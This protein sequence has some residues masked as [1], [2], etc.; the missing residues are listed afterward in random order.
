[1]TSYPS[2]SIEILDPKTLEV[3]TFSDK[4]F[5]I[6]PNFIFTGSFDPTQDRVEFFVYSENNVL[7]YSDG[8]FN[9]W[10]NTL[11][12][13]LASQGISTL[14]LD[15]VQAVSDLGI[16]EGKIKTL[17]NFISDELGSSVDNPF[18]I[19]EISGDRTELRLQ[20]NFTSNADLEVLFTEFKSRI[21]S[22]VYFDEFY[23]NF[24]D[25]NLLI[26][27]NILLDTTGG[28]VSFFVKLYEPLP[29]NILL[30]DIVW[31]S[32]KVGESTSYLISFPETSLVVDNL[33]YLGGPNINID[34][35][36]S[37]GI[38]TAF[39]TYSTLISSSL[40]SSYNQLQNIL[41][42]KGIQITPD[43]TNF[44]S[45]VFFSNAS[46][47]LVNFYTKVS[48]IESYQ[49]DLSIINSITG[50]TSQ[51]YSVSASRVTIEQNIT[52]IISNFDGYENY[53]YFQSGS[54]TW[55][56]SNSTYPY[57]LYS[58][59]SSQVLTWLGSSDET[60][61]YY[62]GQLYSSSIY[63][64]L[65]QNNLFY[66]IPAYLRN[67]PN[68][69]QYFLFIEMMGQFFDNI[70]IYTDAITDK[71]KADNRINDGVSK[72]LVATV[73]ESL[74]QKLYTNQFNSNDIYSS[75]IGVDPQ[76]NLSPFPN[77]TGTYPVTGSGLEYIQNFVSASS[78]QS[79]IPLTEANQRLYKRIYHI[80]P[81][82]VKKKGTLEALKLIRNAYGIPSTIL[83]FNE[84]GGK[85]GYT[86][87]YDYFNDKYNLAFD[88]QASASII[89]P[90]ESLNTSF[91]S[92]DAGT[93]I[94][95]SI[96]FRFKT[97]GIPS[98]SIS[99]SL[100]IKTSTN[101]SSATPITSSWDM[102][103]FLFYTGSGTTSGSYSGSVADPY[104]QYGTLRFY[105]SGSAAQTSNN[106]YYQSSGIYL[107]FFDGGW[108]NIM[109]QR[110]P[111]NAAAANTVTYNI[112]AANKI[113]DENEGYQLGF[114]G[115]ASFTIAAASSSINN[116]WIKSTTSSNTAYPA[117]IYFGGSIS[118]SKTLTTTLTT[119]G[120]FT[121]SFQEIRY[122]SATLPTTSF[123]DYVMNPQSITG[124][125][126]SGA[127]YIDGSGNL[128]G[129]S[130]GL[131]AFRAP[132]GSEL[133]TI[134][135][136][137]SAT[138]I[139][140]ASYSSYHP[141]ISG[142]NP[143]SSFNSLSSSYKVLYYPISSSLTSSFSTNNYE[144]YY[145]AA[146]IIGTKN[147]TS[148]NIQ[149]ISSSYPAGGV[150]S[151]YISL[152]QNY[153][154]TSSIVY[155]TNLFEAAFSPQE[156]L[157]D[158]IIDS[159]G[160]FD[161]GNYIGD[162][163]LLSQSLTTYPD[164]DQLAAYHFQKYS[165][166]Y[167]IKDYVRLIKFIDN[168]LFKFIKDYIPARADSSTGVVVK[169]HYLERNRHRMVLPQMSQSYNQFTS[170]INSPVTSSISGGVY[171][172][173]DEGTTYTFTGST[174]G[175][176]DNYNFVSSS[177][178]TSTVGGVVVTQSYT[179]SLNTIAGTVTTINNYQTEF[180]TG[181]YSGSTAR[182]TSQSLFNVP[183]LIPSGAIDFTSSSPSR[184][185]IAGQI[186]YNFQ[187]ENSDYYPLVNNINTN[188]PNTNY[189]DLDFT[190][191]SIQAANLYAVLSG[192]ALRAQTPDSN[193]TSLKSILPRYNGSKL[194]ALNYNTYAS[195]SSAALL[196]DGTIGAYSGDVSYG[197]NAVITKNPQYFAHFTYGYPSLETKNTFTFDIDKLY[198]IVITGQTLSTSGGPAD[199]KEVSNTIVAGAISIGKK[200]ISTVGDSEINIFTSDVFEQGRKLAVILTGDDT[201]PQYRG[202]ILDQVSIAGQTD[203]TFLPSGSWNIFNS[204]LGYT[205]TLANQKQDTYNQ[206]N[207][208][209]Q[210]AFKRKNQRQPKSTEYTNQ[211]V[212]YLQ[213]SPTTPNPPS[214]FTG[215]FFTT[216]S[217]C[218]LLT[219]SS[220]SSSYIDYGGDYTFKTTN[221]L[222]FIHNYNYLLYNN[223]TS[224]TAITNPVFNTVTL[225][226]IDNSLLRNYYIWDPENTGVE[227]YP[228]ALTPFVI[229]RGDIIKISYE[230]RNG[231]PRT[232]E[233][234][235]TGVETTS[236]EAYN[237]S[238][239][240][241]T[242]TTTFTPVT[243]PLYKKI[244]VT[245][246]P[247]TVTYPIPIVDSHIMGSCIIKR[248][249]SD[250]SKIII[251]ANNPPQAEGIQTQV[252]DGYLIPKDL[253]QSQLLTVL[254]T[255]E[256]INNAGNQNQR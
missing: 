169:Q 9:A 199:P 239:Q 67:D 243:V 10:T 42:Q 118:G 251:I 108:W 83:R 223:V 162:P 216:G 74:G 86:S 62:G 92:P 29:D 44:E 107:P 163:R 233:F 88:N 232:Q 175:V 238:Y 186:L 205:V 54:Y 204:G 167:N 93:N 187:Y 222:A 236:D 203:F 195:G 91:T 30:Q 56:K 217:G 75:L 148:D 198:P 27:I 184:L 165:N 73:L 34:V 190:T 237:Q 252:T 115:S 12:P 218:L 234:T 206:D 55:P 99:Q 211:Y 26:G 125:I 244:N 194:Q 208:A 227:Q 235:V 150:L 32:T 225:N 7:L 138:S 231:V 77:T 69:T 87:R 95:T 33:I 189:Y 96:Q 170:S 145:Y 49:N 132:L 51:S 52:N 66:S 122:F 123:Y 214:G 146:P 183:Y 154:F 246:D 97:P 13:L 152:E 173:I 149:I 185:T 128:I 65:N 28:N 200:P 240:F 20:T 158:D 72:D 81:Y 253:N 60:S 131:L 116:S 109:L 3:P 256:Q 180:Y 103:L 120:L 58:T 248:P 196:L 17:F 166:K 89:V 121:G 6:I 19:K 124:L 100:F 172:N 94:P 1:M 250:N 14:N 114:I 249:K 61:A 230:D 37:V 151:Q 212:V 156:E 220:Y 202:S 142:S 242:N 117:G 47:R 111:Y 105:L 57:A 226:A 79:L 39:K 177:Y 171:Y 4:D 176:L 179:Q 68:N 229:L 53:L 182:A 135:T 224:S 197:P 38:S 101:N 136:A 21:S 160:R 113:Y 45:F 98:G 71:L 134:F 70:W 164:L 254:S 241:S 155:N 137:S 129:S 133:E 168:S 228:T 110:S 207:T 76:G 31:I 159:L 191:N 46:Q 188:R 43:Y 15:P 119:P 161:I 84:F 36:K 210:I 219:G 245:P 144:T 221:P 209:Y 82:L 90:W 40:T 213:G 192:S 215:S 106:G 78:L 174:G 85:N 102:G 48:N 80:L 112:Y 143:T 64:N 126:P 63:D 2:A 181:N 127:N 147:K 139:N 141:A 41:Q 50:S 130:Y 22:Q 59:G 11:D 157:N 247:T 140:T 5:A 24:G 35:N 8:D 16:T 25:N 104:N 193:Y 153:P 201:K 178:L 255:I 23:L 18:F